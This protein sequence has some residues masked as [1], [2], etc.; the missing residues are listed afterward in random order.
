[1]GLRRG[2][3]E[4]RQ[5]VLGREIPKPGPEVNGTLAF[6][7]RELLP[8]FR[9]RKVP[10]A[11]LLVPCTH[12][13][14]CHHVDAAHAQHTVPIST[15]EH[16]LTAAALSHTHTHTEPSQ[17]HR[18]TA[19]L[20]WKGS[21]RSHSPSPA[22]GRDPP[23][24]GCPGPP[25]ASCT[26][27]MGH[28]QLRAAVP[29][30]RPHCRRPPHMSATICPPVK[31]CWLFLSSVCLSGVSRRICSMTLQDTEVMLAAL[32]H[33]FLYSPFPFSSPWELCWAAT[34]SAV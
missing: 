6:V 15:C 19:R 31:P 12:A 17:N 8:P 13:P 24:S 1:M 5:E 16:R 27:G 22:V 23:R 18:I 21:K 33:I 10:R 4:S 2:V 30:P 11:A 25:M 28:S 32:P 9:P 14:H 34:T 20:C 29:R 26:A 3:C 7:F